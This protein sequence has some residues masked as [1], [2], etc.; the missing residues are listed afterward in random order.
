MSN[1]F[2]TRSP[3]SFAIYPLLTPPP[4]GAHTRTALAN[5]RSCNHGI[6]TG[7]N[8]EPVEVTIVRVMQNIHV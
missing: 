6:H 8:C 4:P 2:V 7:I 1:S 3:H 5:S